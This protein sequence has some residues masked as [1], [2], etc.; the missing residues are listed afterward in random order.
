FRVAIPDQTDDELLTGVDPEKLVKPLV[1]CYRSRRPF[2]RGARGREIQHQVLD[3]AA[4]AA[5]ILL[6]P[7]AILGAAAG[8]D[9]PSRDRRRGRC[10]EVAELWALPLRRHGAGERDTIVDRLRT[11]QVEMPRLRY[12]M[13]RRPARGLDRSHDQLAAD[14]LLQEQL[15]GAAAPDAFRDC[16]E[17]VVVFGSVCGHAFSM[18]IAIP[19]PTPMHIVQSA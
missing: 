8:H 15:D 4:A 16:R 17:C 13:V 6:L 19:W 10:L 3:R 11:Q 9:E 7:V 1:L 2:R 14:R 18:I 12:V 5:V